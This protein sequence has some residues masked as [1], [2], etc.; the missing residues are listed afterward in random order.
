L[1]RNEGVSIAVLGVARTYPF[2][3]FVQVQA[4]PLQHE[5]GGGSGSVYHYV[6]LMQQLQLGHQRRF[7]TEN[8]SAAL[9]SVRW[10]IVQAE[11]QNVAT[12]ER[13][14]FTALYLRALRDLAASVHALNDHVAEVS[15]KRLAAGDV[16]AADTTIAR[17]DRQTALQQARLAETNYRT[18][19]LDLARQL[20]I[21]PQAPLEPSGSL[22]DFVWHVP[23]RC[24]DPSSEP[25]DGLNDAV[26]GGA[27]GD[28]DDAA[29]IAADWAV[30][31]PDVLAA[32][33]DL[34]AARANIGL[35][36]GS[37]IPDLQV[38]PYYQ[39]S[40]S[41]STLVG[42][43]AQTDVP[44]LNTGL[45]LVRQREAE[46]R[47]QAAVREQLQTRAQLEAAAAADR[48]RRALLLVAE[49]DFTASAT[50]PQEFQRLEAQ[51]VAGEVDIVRIVAA[52]TSLIQLR[53]AQLDVLNE[54]A[55]A[56]AALTAASGIPPERLISEHAE[57][58]PST[59]R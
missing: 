23:P 32:R 29:M 22:I 19:V 4:T 51:F 59:M 38:G 18:A 49:A 50:S 26:L 25:I 3:P 47:R 37:R 42:F 35:A 55:Q 16:A 34:A 1:R 28:G 46:Y 44:V 43:R 11:L 9:A 13:L 36:R 10:N 5:K 27:A 17:L 45:P 53:R 40:E 7:R 30:S 33:A 56:A 12:T 48:Y 6:L 14:F 24:F 39:Q 54:A 31:R 20:N 8:A 52:R 58:V 2:N 15:E 41:G 21:A 57:P